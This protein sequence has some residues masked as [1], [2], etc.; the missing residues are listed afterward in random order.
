VRSCGKLAGFT[1]NRTNVISFGLA[2]LGS[3][4]PARSRKV[5]SRT[6]TYIGGSTCLTAFAAI[7]EAR[8]DPTSNGKA[9]LK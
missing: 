2:T 3:A 8:D 5:V 1:P 6:A 4:G 7:R 9:I